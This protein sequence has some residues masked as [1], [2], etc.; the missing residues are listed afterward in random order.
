VTTFQA[1]L[2]ETQYVE[3]PAHAVPIEEIHREA[4]SASAWPAGAAPLLIRPRSLA[5]VRR[6]GWGMARARARRRLRA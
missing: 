4:T 5:F 3:G 2:A 6:K 1:D